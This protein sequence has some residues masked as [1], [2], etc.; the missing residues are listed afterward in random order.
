MHIVSSRIYGVFGISKPSEV[1]I[2]FIYE[3][4]VVSPTSSLPSLRRG[5]FRHCLSVSSPPP[6]SL[7]TR[8][9]PWKRVMF[10]RSGRAQKSVIYVKRNFPSDLVSVEHELAPMDF[11]LS[12]Q[13]KNKAPAPVQIT[14]EQL[15]REAKE[16]QLELVPP[17]CGHT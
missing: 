8:R 14:A 5:S 1:V 7:F 2:Q 15:L 17:V 10:V 3:F 12:F 4:T 13:V 6:M 11:F 16:R 9:G